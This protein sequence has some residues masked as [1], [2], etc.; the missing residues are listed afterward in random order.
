MKVMW[1]ISW[2]LYY[3]VLLNFKPFKPSIWYIYKIFKE[4]NMSGIFR[5]SFWAIEP[6]R[7]DKNGGKFRKPHF[8]GKRINEMLFHGSE[9]ILQLQNFQCCIWIED[10]F[11]RNQWRSHDI[12][13]YLDL[14]LEF[15]FLKSFIW[16]IR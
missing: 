15:G 6:I 16:H 9:L 2:T 14:F 10:F 4:L 5:F 7:K 12:M 13:V 1:Y 11:C 3:L 8:S